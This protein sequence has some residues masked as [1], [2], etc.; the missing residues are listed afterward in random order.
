MLFL[1]FYRLFHTKV[2]FLQNWELK[3][4]LLWFI[5]LRDH[6]SGPVSPFY[7]VVDE[8]RTQAMASDSQLR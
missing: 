4:D 7:I 1:D 5:V 3:G 6:G 2:K 8:R